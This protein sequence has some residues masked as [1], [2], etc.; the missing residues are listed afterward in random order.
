MVREPQAGVTEKR[1]VVCGIL[2]RPVVPTPDVMPEWS[3]APR[4]EA[5]SHVAR[6]RRECVGQA[7]RELQGATPCCRQRE[8]RSPVLWPQPQRRSCQHLGGHLAADSSPA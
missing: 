8:S 7:L 4:E 3:P 2:S 5:D 1:P 6:G